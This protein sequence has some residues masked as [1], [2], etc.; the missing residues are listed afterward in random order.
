V[1]AVGTALG[2]PVAADASSLASA[3]ADRGRL[4]V[5]LDNFE[6]VAAFAPETIGRWQGAAESEA[7]QLFVERA[8]AVR[9]DFT[10]TEADAP[11]VVHIVRTLDGLPLAIEL[12]A[13]R[14]RVFTPSKLVERLAQRFE[15]LAGG[16]RDASGRQATLRGAI[17][18]S[19]SMLAPFEQAAL[20]QASVFRGGF[21]LES[22]E[23]VLDL[24]AWPQ[25]EAGEPPGEAAGSPKGNQGRT[26]AWVPDVVQ[27]LRDKSLL[28]SWT[29]PD[30]GE[31]RFGMYDSIREY[32]AEKLAQSRAEGAAMLRHAEHY[33]RV[34]GAWAEGVDLHGGLA[35]LRNLAGE[36]DNLLAI[37][38][39]AVR[40]FGASASALGVRAVLAL[41]PV[42]ATRGPFG[43]FIRLADEVLAYGRAL[44]VD[45][46][47]LAHVLTARGWMRRMAGDPAAARADFEA[48]LAI[49]KRDGERSLE[50]RVVRLLGLVTW[51]EGRFEESRLEYERA[52]EIHRASGDRQLE[53]R[54]LG[55]LANFDQEEGKLGEAQ[56]R[57][58]EAI[59]ILREVGDRRTEGIFVGYLGALL[60]ERERRDAARAMYE[61]AVAIQ[62][63]FRDRRH[64]AMFVGYLGTLAHER[65]DLDEARRSYRHSIRLSRELGDRR[66]EGFYLSY[67]GVVEAAGD[68]REEA[69]AAS[70]R[71]SKLLEQ[72]RLLSSMIGLNRAHV[73][74]LLART[75]AA[76]KLVTAATRAANE[77]IAEVEAQG[78]G[79]WTGADS[80]RSLAQASMDV[81][82]ALRLLKRTLAGAKA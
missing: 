33:V 72:D 62:R 66:Q 52:L 70:A 53:G 28:R 38:R 79:G 67:L 32:A 80:G 71:A 10:L 45:E 25:G 63:E 75:A 65:G 60:Q 74:L 56:E 9:P 55:D 11:Y 34:A 17:D 31:L 1:R 20:A 50:G 8:R 36:A 22:A 59:A 41:E 13:S 68:H 54:T 61:R 44:G 12:A 4:L 21:T 16:T 77:R 14:M 7:V 19:W 82:I 5:V 6:Q 51:D 42:F 64:E 26:I 43:G 81:R 46:A 2:L 58:E 18:W 27:S 3:L 29:P 78:S 49:A 73:E 57:Y 23:V 47:L 40:G 39:R 48:A 30:T 76:P 35:R 15:L 37:H 24:S 69:E